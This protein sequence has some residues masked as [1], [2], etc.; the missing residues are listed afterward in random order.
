MKTRVEYI[1][2][3]KGYGSIAIMAWHVH[4]APFFSIHYM[5]FWVLPMFF[6][7]SGVFAKTEMTFI[8]LIKRDVKRFFVPMLFLFYVI[9]KLKVF[10]WLGWFGMKSLH[11]LGLHYVFIPCYLFVLPSLASIP[12]WEK[13]SFFILFILFSSQIVL[14]YDS[15]LKKTETWLGNIVSRYILNFKR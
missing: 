4:L 11:F 15:Y 13:Y 6:L 12:S 2:L 5:K 9:E 7:L 8:E 14:L 10:S 1:D 3:A